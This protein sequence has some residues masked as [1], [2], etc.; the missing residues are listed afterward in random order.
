MRPAPG[1]LISGSLSERPWPKLRLRQHDSADSK[2]PASKMDRK[3]G[4]LSTFDAPSTAP[5]A[6]LEQYTNMA[7]SLPRNVH[8][9]THPCVRAKLSQL[10]SHTTNS[11]DVQRLVHEIATMVGCEALANGAVEAVEGGTVSHPILPT[12]ADTAA[13]NPLRSS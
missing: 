6:S 12:A 10:R 11:A 2:H 4:I 3:Y 1:P 5:P 8:I 13:D 9:S 7:P